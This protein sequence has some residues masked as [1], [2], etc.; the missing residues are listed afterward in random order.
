MDIAVHWG[1]LRHLR[2]EIAMNVA[3]PICAIGFDIT[4]LASLIAIKASSATLVVYAAVAGLALIFAGERLFL[5]RDF[6]S[7]N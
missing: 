5:R 4:V 7:K 3:I 1:V 6:D 2:R